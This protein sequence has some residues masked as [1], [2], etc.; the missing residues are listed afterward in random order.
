MSGH[1]DFSSPVVKTDTQNILREKKEKRQ[2]IH[3]CS[4]EVKQNAKRLFV[5]IPATHLFKVSI[6]EV[7]QHICLHGC[8]DCSLKQCCCL[9]SK[10]LPCILVLI[11]MNTLFI[12]CIV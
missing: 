10:Q 12:L 5:Q 3:T 2:L 8:G 9:V 7:D 4:F 1:V 6:C 11:S